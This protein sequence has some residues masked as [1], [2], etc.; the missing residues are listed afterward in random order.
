MDANGALDVMR[1]MVSLKAV[2]HRPQFAAAFGDAGVQLW[3][4][5][6]DRAACDPAV[7]PEQGLLAVADK[8]IKPL[9]IKKYSSETVLLLGQTHLLCIWLQVVSMPR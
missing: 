7:L 6:A 4:D 9:Q 3:H 2:R 1:P 5:L 8:E